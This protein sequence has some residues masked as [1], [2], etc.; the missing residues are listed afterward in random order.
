MT[1]MY[2]IKRAILFACVTAALVLA[3][4]GGGGGSSTATTN[5]PAPASTPAGG[6]TT[7]TSTTS[8]P[9]STS[10]PPATVTTVQ[11]V[12][13]V[14]VGASPYGFAN[15]LMASVTVCVPGSS[16]CQTVDNVLVD[17]GS[18]G[19]RLF[20]SALSLPLP[21]VASGTRAL[22]TCAAFGSGTTWG[23]V[24][25][26]DI[27]LAGEVALSTSIQLISD[28]AYPSVPASCSSQG[29]QTINSPS[30]LG[31][32]GILG[33]GLQ[34]ADCPA[35]VAHAY[36]VYYACSISGCSATKAPLSAQ[37][38]NPVSN[39]ATDS[40]GVIVQLPAVPAG[41]AVSATGS[42]VFGIGTQNNNGLGSAAVYTTDPSQNTFSAQYKG[43]TY[44]YAFI[45]SGS[46]GLFFDDTSIIQ[47]AGGSSFFCPTTALSLS[48]VVQGLNGA[49]TSVGFQVGNADALYGSG[50]NAMNDYAAQLAST[51]DLGL[52]FFYG[53]NVYTAIVGKATPAG[54]GPYFA[55]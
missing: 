22:A 28:P 11:N 4:C 15:L 14:S 50:A 8:T 45:D 33:V 19:L 36:N 34:S 17:T 29:F 40:N 5:S 44:S 32:N 38:T 16:S 46:N 24:R 13:T 2:G 35:C 43:A 7:P 6:P 18:Y 39:F 53:R 49:S 30:V 23:T 48:A 9:T 21:Q 51:F 54:P 41:G 47:C 37:V 20:A 55:F 42:L 1:R 27:R 26:A 3:G 25:T 10:S 12:Q 52:P 31:A